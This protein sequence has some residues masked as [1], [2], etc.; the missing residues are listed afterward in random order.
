[1]TTDRENNEITGG[2][3]ADNANIRTSADLTE[4]SAFRGGR[5]HEHDLSEEREVELTSEKSSH[6]LPTSNVKKQYK[7]TVHHTNNV[8]QMFLNKNP[9]KT[10]PASII[11]I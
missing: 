9:N 8:T 6:L 10:I 5:K 3:L 2:G 1:M 4:N 11:I 7:N